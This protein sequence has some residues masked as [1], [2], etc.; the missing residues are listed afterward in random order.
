[1][2]AMN[3]NLV[4]KLYATV[5]LTAYFALE[6]LRC[7]FLVVSRLIDCS[8]RMH[9]R[10]AF[11]GGRLF[12]LPSLGEYRPYPI[13]ISG[14]RLLLDTKDCQWESRLRSAENQPCP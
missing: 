1:M 6:S 12:C 10:R 9:F 4:S 7:V 14:G 13:Q 3:T 11:Q 5:K 8:F 2:F